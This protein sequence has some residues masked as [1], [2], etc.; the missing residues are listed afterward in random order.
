MI[1]PYKSLCLSPELV[2]VCRYSGDTTPSWR[3]SPVWFVAS[4][5]PTV[6][7]PWSLS[8]PSRSFLFLFELFMK[9]FS[10]LEASLD[11]GGNLHLRKSSSSNR[12]MKLIQSIK[13]C[14]ARVLWSLRHLKLRDLWIFCPWPQ[15][16]CH[17]A[18]LTR[19]RILNW[20]TKIR[21]I[22]AQFR[23]HDR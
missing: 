4:P 8:Q 20:T 1:S 9:Y 18:H 23:Q 19:L 14:M 3:L 16:T 22:K 11:V 15:I 12:V 13:D 5:R 21:W 6:F 2:T 7:Y 17:K 10:Y